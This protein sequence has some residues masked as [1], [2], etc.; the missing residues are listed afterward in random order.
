M[1]RVKNEQVAGMLRDIANVL[2]IQ[3]VAYKP[4]AYQRAARAVETL[5]ENIEEVRARGELRDI[6]GVGESIAQKIEEYLD[7][8]EL[9]YLQDLREQV[10]DEFTE[11]LEVEG[12][13]PKTALKL[14][15]KLGIENIAELRESAEDHEIQDLEGFGKKS[16]RN[17]LENIASYRESSDRFLLGDALPI[18]EEIVAHLQAL[19]SVSQI[20]VAGS[21]RRRKPTVGDID[22]LVVTTAPEEVMDRF[23]SYADVATVLASGSKK[24]TVRLANNLDVDV[25]VIEAS[26]Y[27]AA[28]QYFTG[29]RDHNI[30]LRRIAQDQDWKLNEYGLFAANAD[31]DTD[32]KLAGE[33]EA[34]IYARLGL[35]Y[36]VPELRENRGE[37]P[38][39]Q[40]GTLPDLLSLD[41]IRGDVH[42]HSS[43]SADASHSLDEMVEAAREAG[44]EYV[45]F[46]DHAKGLGIAGG[47]DAED[48]QARQQEIDEL[49]AK[50]GDF[51]VLAGVELNI[52]KDGGLDLPNEILQ[53][54]DFVVASVH[55]AFKQP[56]DKMTARVITAMHNDHV[57]AIGHPTGRLLNERDALALDLDELFDAAA[58]LGVYMEINAFP[59]RLD[60]S[61]RLVKRARDRGVQFVIDTDAHSTEHLRYMALGV[62]MARR[63]WLEA[64]DV[65]NTLEWEDLK[66]EL[67]L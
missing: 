55:H 25:R 32:E 26:S 38:A 52:D 54:F 64:V 15:R 50:Y 16:E 53:D 12:V 47:L 10:S 56:E 51:R 33:D 23:T 61:G 57:D 42:I 2:K 36:V 62:A 24:S 28:L 48:F 6:S 44:Y 35:A 45:A 37:I 1:G 8:G 13:G 67:N 27:G 20:A 11:L 31:A 60:L 63:G 58:D 30:E 3:D 40:E 39:A 18:A 19:D 5:S 14:H 41:Q 34:G 49:D 4:R 7:T 22:I 17:L 66:E 59:S 29:A 65:L 9:E 46:C 43:W 21:I